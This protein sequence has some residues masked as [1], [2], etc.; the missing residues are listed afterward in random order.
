MASTLRGEASTRKLRAPLSKAL[1]FKTM[2]ILDIDDLLD[3]CIE[4]ESSLGEREMFL[5]S[6]AYLESVADMQG[7]DH[8]FTH[9]MHLYVPLCQILKLSGDLD[10]L[11]ILKN[12]ESHFSAFNVRFG[13]KEIDTFL[14]IATESYFASCPDWR[15][16]FSG[17]TEQRWS[18]I[19]KYLESIGFQLKTLQG[20]VSARP[21]A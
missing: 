21:S 2:N 3:K 16:M 12:Y 15:E 5:Y 7:W 14:S 18:L 20:A 9:S 11:R 13:A 10:S 6:V 8:F 4:V 17:L 1:C 19:S